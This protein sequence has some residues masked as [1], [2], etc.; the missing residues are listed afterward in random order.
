MSASYIYQIVLLC[1]D[2]QK[3]RSYI[4]LCLLGVT[5]EYADLCE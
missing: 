1:M 2:S 4:I 5:V 3:S